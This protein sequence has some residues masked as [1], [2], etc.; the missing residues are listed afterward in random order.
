MGAF[1][2]E[3]VVILRHD[4]LRTD[5]KMELQN[6]SQ[7]IVD[8]WFILVLISFCNLFIVD[9]VSGSCVLLYSHLNL[10]F[11]LMISRMALLI[12]DLGSLQ[13]Y[14]SGVDVS[15]AFMSL[16]HKVTASSLCPSWV[17]MSVSILFGQSFSVL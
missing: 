12:G 7:L 10:R 13:L 15:T 1:R 4:F 3:E 16:S 17:V 6:F 14:F 2:F 8:S 9:L 11:S 5:S